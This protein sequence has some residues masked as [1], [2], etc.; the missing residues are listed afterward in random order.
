MIHSLVPRAGTQPTHT[1]KRVGMLSLL[2]S[3]KYKD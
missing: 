2:D 1:N 3:V